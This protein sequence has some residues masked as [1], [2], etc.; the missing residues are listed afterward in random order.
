MSE[1]T[2]K[3]PP[4][5]SQSFGQSEHFSAPLQ[6]ASPQTAHAPAVSQPLAI[7]LSQSD[8]PDWQTRPHAALVHVEFAPG[9]VGHA[10]PQSPQFEESEDTSCSQP[11]AGLLSQLPQPASHALIAHA[12]ELHVAVLTCCNVLQLFWHDPQ[13]VASVLTSSS[14]PFALLASQSA[15]PL[16]QLAIPQ[17]PSA[18]V[19]LA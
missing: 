6:C 19:V 17:P 16:L 3:G 4:P 11:V 18:H 8:R 7:E 9:A 14:Q 10:C 2:N 15:Q 1:C 5:H 13:C 12:A